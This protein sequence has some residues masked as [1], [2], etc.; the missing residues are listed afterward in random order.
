MPYLVMIS[1]RAALSA[2]LVFVCLLVAR[3]LM[4][5]EAPEVAN[6]L[7]GGCHASG[8]LTQQSSAPLEEVALRIDWSNIKLR[9]WMAANH[10]FVP[11]LA[12]NASELEDLRHYLENLR[13]QSFLGGLGGAP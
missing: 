2:G 13:R 3:P 8:L 9:Q 12:A 11:A 6:R 5:S 1:R 10:R 7:C 4:A